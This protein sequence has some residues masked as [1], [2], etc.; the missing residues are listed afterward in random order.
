[1]FGSCYG[2]SGVRKL[3]MVL[4]I[5]AFLALG[6]LKGHTTCT[7]LLLYLGVV[8]EADF[9]LSLSLCTRISSCKDPECLEAAIRGSCNQ[10]SIVMLGEDGSMFNLTCSSSHLIW[11][12]GKVGIGVACKEAYQNHTSRPCTCWLSDARSCHG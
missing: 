1:M 8:V 10:L 11:G 9:R 7:R 12:G 2:E 5:F 6:V 4:F 3:E